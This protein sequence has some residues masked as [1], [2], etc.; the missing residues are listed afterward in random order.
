ME[1][2]NNKNGYYNDKSTFDL[3]AQIEV[4]S[5]VV[6]SYEESNINNNDKSLEEIKRLSEE[7]NRLN[8]EVEYLKGVCEIL[9]EKNSGLIKEVKLLKSNNTI[10]PTIES[11]KFYNSSFKQTITKKVTSPIKKKLNNNTISDENIELNIS[12]EVSEKMEINNS[13][14]NDLFNDSFQEKV[15]KKGIPAKKR[16]FETIDITDD[17]QPPLKKQKIE[18]VNKKNNNIMSITLSSEKI[19]CLAKIYFENQQDIA[20]KINNNK[21]STANGRKLM[22]RR[23][24]DAQ[25]FDLKDEVLENKIDQLLT[26]KDAQSSDFWVEVKKCNTKPISE[27]FKKKESTT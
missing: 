24:K 26:K 18:Q 14:K 25:G 23:F 10:N 1:Y 27:Y 17:L 11:E 3:S 4:N 8:K 12:V 2:L 7:N 5:S 20:P 22:I 9:V 13:I 16:K 21:M 15:M 19:K 6:N